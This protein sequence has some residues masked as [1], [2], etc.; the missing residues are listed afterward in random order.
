MEKKGKK[1]LFGILA[2]VAVIV[3]LVILFYLFV[4]ISAWL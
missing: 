4:L 2:G 3:A 1:I